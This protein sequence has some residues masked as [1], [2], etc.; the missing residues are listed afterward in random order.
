MHVGGSKEQELGTQL[1]FLPTATGE[2]QGL[3]Y[4]RDFI[5][6]GE[7][8]DLIS[9]IQALPLAPFQFGAF[10]GKRRVASFGWRYDYSNHRLEQADELPAWLSPMIARIEAFGDLRQ[11]AVRQILC[12]EYAEGAGIG[13]HRD[14]PHFDE[15]FGLSLGSACTFRFR[16]KA[17]GKWERFSFQVEPRSLYMMSGEA[18]HLWQHSIP[19]VETPRYSVTFRTMDNKHAD[20]G[21]REEIR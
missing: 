20:I 17:A 21:S 15:V 5:S 4:Q 18:R 13:W 2:P 8:T 12:T 6:R 1:S 19:P 9:R 3:R 16:R 14:K 10:E 11:G 7:Q